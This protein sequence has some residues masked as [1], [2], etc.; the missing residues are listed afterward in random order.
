MVQSQIGKIAARIA[1]C[2]VVPHGKRIA[3]TRNVHLHRFAFSGDRYN[4]DRMHVLVDGV[5]TFKAV[6]NP[7]TAAERIARK[8][9]LSEFSQA[10]LGHETESCFACGG[11][12]VIGQA[13]KTGDCPF[14]GKT[15]GFATSAAPE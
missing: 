9:N 10:H 8:G 15:S 13:T 3:I 12:W 7:G 11:E 4:F 14:C 2:P 6:I 5:G 1:G